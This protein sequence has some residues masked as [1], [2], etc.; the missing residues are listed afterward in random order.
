M[1][2]M[3]AVDPEVAKKEAA[4]THKIEYKG[5]WSRENSSG[6]GGGGRYATG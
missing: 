3:A 5:T 1:P 4:T 2:V 6:G